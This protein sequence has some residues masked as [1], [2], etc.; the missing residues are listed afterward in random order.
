[1]AL[2]RT[3]LSIQTHQLIPVVLPRP[4]A[5]DHPNAPELHPR[6]RVVNLLRLESF[7]RFL[8]ATKTAASQHRWFPGRAIP[9]THSMPPGA[10]FRSTAAFFLRQIPLPGE[11]ALASPTVPAA[12]AHPKPSIPQHAPQTQVRTGSDDRRGPQLPRPVRFH[13]V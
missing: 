5:L 4:R 13:R 11:S 9:K 8:A 1:P 2:K 6:S 12:V 10:S 3:P 7:R